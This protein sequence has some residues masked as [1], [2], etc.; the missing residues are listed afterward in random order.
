M[1]AHAIATIASRTIRQIA[2]IT[3]VMILCG[4]SASNDA[5]LE[6]NGTARW[7]RHAHGALYRLGAVQGNRFLAVAI[8]GGYLP[9]Y[10][11]RSG[12]LCFVP[13]VNCNPEI[14]LRKKPSL[15]DEERI[16]M[17]SGTA[18]KLMGIKL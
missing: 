10:A 16:A 8:G 15:S 17:L 12:Q 3:G 2:E 11:P 1:N 14:K 6:M 18:A 4:W 9:S 7:A 13:P 5:L